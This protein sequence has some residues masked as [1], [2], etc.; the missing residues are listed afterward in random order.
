MDLV[1]NTRMGASGVAKTYKL[2]GTVMESALD[3]GLILRNP[4]RIKDAGTEHLPEMLDD[5]E[6]QLAA[7]L[8]AV[9]IH[10][11]F[12]SSKFLHSRGKPVSRSRHTSYPLSFRNEI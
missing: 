1:V 10:S 3:A 4:C 5:P 7:G 2:M 12:G 8:T 6:T 9:A 11:R